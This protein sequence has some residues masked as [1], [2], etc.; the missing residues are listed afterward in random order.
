MRFQGIRRFIGGDA[1]EYLKNQLSG[2]IDDLVTGLSKLTFRDNFLQYQT[3]VSIAAGVEDAVEHHLGV[4]PAG[5]IIFAC[6]GGILQDGPTAATDM[7]WYLKNVSS[8]STANAT[9]IFFR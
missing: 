7:F 3:T 2:G 9:V 8:T 4:I 5:R 6:E 1:A